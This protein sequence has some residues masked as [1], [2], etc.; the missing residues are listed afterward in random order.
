MNV[1]VT[2]GAPLPF[3]FDILATAHQYGNRAFTQYPADIP[4]YFKQT[5]PEGHSWER[6][7]IFEDGAVCTASSNIRL[8]TDGLWEVK[9]ISFR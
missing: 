2:K 4:D 7:M 5:F 9:V 6:S 1:V 8:G 3:A